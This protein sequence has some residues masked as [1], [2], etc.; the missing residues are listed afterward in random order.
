[1]SLNSWSQCCFDIRGNIWPF[2]SGAI[3]MNRMNLFV[4][5]L[6]QLI[7]PTW[8]KWFWKNFPFLSSEFYNIE[9]WFSLSPSPKIRFLWFFIKPSR[10][11]MLLVLEICP[12]DSVAEGAIL[13][14]SKKIR[15][16]KI[17]EELNKMILKYIWQ[18]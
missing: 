12:S 13:S 18:E 3:A 16:K 10:L 8:R 5:T 4:K 15:E 17:F 6:K 2:W 11:V 7:T 14:N 1:M 9:L